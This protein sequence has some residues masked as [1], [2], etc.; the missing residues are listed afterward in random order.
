MQ[1][2]FAYKPYRRR[3][4][5]P[6][7]T[8]YGTWRT[9][10]GW[11]LRLQAPDG[12]C[13]FGE[14]API[15]WFHPAESLAKVAQA[16][17]ELPEQINFQ[18]DSLPGDLLPSIR[19]GLETA[20]WQLNAWQGLPAPQR[21][22]LQTACLLPQLSAD[23][24][25]LDQALSAGYTTFKIKIGVDASDVEKEQCVTILQ[26]LQGRG[27]LRLDA[28]GGLTLDEAANWL[29]LLDSFDAVEF[30]EQP[31]SRGAE[32]AM[33]QLSRNYRTPIALDESVCT[34]AD[35]KACWTEFPQGP[36]VVKLGILGSPHAWLDWRRAHPEPMIVYSS[37]L[38]TV[39]GSAASLRIAAADPQQPLAFGYGVSELFYPDLLQLKWQGPSIPLAD[40]PS[41]EEFCSIWEAI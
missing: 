1:L 13:G 9:R 29:E 18:L 10:D 12:H 17:Q 41:L 6:L 7:Q 11:L 40:L 27:K 8:A 21:R 16:L 14:V 28:N 20:C 3:F 39:I 31:L 32:D 30:L 19:F 2:N 35:L 34:L 15:P 25:A 5:R 26:K 23:P 36:F 38:E 22:A 24:A 4:A 33:L 37:C